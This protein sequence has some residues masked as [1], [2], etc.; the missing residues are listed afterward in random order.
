MKK[1]DFKNKTPKELATLLAEKKNKLA[2]FRFAVA[3]SN[4][5]NNKE[6]LAL[7]KDIAR[8]LTKLNN[9]QQ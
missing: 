4:T 8:I 3:G 1:I 7:R 2:A 6:G 9:T 5:R